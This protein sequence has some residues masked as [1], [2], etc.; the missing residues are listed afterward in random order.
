MISRR[1]AIRAVLAMPALIMGYLRCKPAQAGD[2]SAEQ[3]ARL[4][5][6][7]VKGYTDDYL[8]DDEVL[9]HFHVPSYKLSDGPPPSCSNIEAL[10]A[11][12]YAECRKT[13]EHKLNDCLQL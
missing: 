12:Y 2:L 10:T 7:W 5:T 3:I 11:E 13:L 4:E 9:L 6:A 1:D 8:S